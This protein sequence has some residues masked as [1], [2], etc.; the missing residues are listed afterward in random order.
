MPLCLSDEEKLCLQT[1]ENNG[2]WDSGWPHV[3]KI[4]WRF[5]GST[6]G[7]ILKNSVSHSTYL[8]S[9]PLKTRRPP[10]TTT[11]HATL[12]IHT[13][14]VYWAFSSKLLVMEKQ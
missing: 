9:S 5:G 11:N 8:T 2:L 6:E 10:L 14:R 1:Q 12:A 7:I 4:L 3:G 13:C